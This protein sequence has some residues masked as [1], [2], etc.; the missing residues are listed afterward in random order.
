MDMQIKKKINFIIERETYC[1]NVMSFKKN[2][3]ATYPRL[4][5][6]IFTKQIGK[7]IEVYVNDMLVK[8]LFAEQHIEH[9]G[10]AFEILRNII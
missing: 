10:E 5:N 4:V 1:Y 3:G 8:Y 6:R 9:L 2:V 7:T